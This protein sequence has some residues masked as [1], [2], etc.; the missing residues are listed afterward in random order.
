M[1]GQGIPEIVWRTAEFFQELVYKCMERTIPISETFIAT[2][3]CADIR[4]MRDSYKLHL[5]A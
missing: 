1:M 3:L 5:G 2:T 4:L